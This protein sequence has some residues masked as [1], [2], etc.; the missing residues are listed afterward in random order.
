MINFEVIEAK[1]GYTNI[2]LAIKVI[3]QIE[4]GELNRKINFYYRLNGYTKLLDTSNFF[5]IYL[6]DN[7]TFNDKLLVN[8]EIIYFNI[9]DPSFNNGADVVIMAVNSYTNSII[10][11]SQSLF[12]KT[13]PIAEPQLSVSFKFDKYLIDGILR[14][15]LITRVFIDM[16]DLTESESIKEYYINQQIVTDGIGNT[17]IIKSTDKP[18]VNGTIDFTYF[19]IPEYG[20]YRIITNLFNSAGKKIFSKVNRYFKM[21]EPL[22]IIYKEKETDTGFSRRVIK[23]YYKNVN[24]EIKQIVKLKVSI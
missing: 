11:K 24:G 20:S 2:K 3:K 17:Q 21:V 19:N 1:R 10:Y 18:L 22:P 8:N 13:K 16:E 4:S 7:K 6:L 14:K 23:A 12:L 5:S 15:A 9:S